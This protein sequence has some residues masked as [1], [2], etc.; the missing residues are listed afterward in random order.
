MNFGPSSVP[1]RQEV[2]AWPAWLTLLCTAYRLTNKASSMLF[3]SARSARMI[4]LMDGYRD[5]GIAT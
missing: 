5:N 2:G 4:F 1:Y 3:L